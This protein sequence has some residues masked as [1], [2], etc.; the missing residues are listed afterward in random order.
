MRRAGRGRVRRRGHRARRSEPPGQLRPPLLQG[1]R[2]RR[3][4]RARGSAASSGGVGRPGDLGHRTRPRRN[5]V[6][7]GDPRARARLGRVLRLR[8]APHRGLLR[9]QQADEGLHRLGQHRYQLAAVHGLLRRRS[10]A[11]LRFRHR[12]RLLRGPRARRSHRAGRIES[13]LVPSGAASAHCG[14]QGAAAEHAG[15][16][17]RSA[18][19]DDGGHRRHAPAD[20]AGRRRGPVPRTSQASVGHRLARPP[21][22]QGAYVRLPGGAVRSGRPR[23]GRSRSPNRDLCRRACRF[24]RAVCRNGTGGH[25]LQP[26]R[27][28]VL[29]RDRQGQRHHQLPSR[30]GAHRQARS[31]ARSR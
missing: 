2:A 7:A 6:H 23:L 5:E 11:R 25:G 12:A 22:H 29:V 17:D 24:L 4:D 20:Q 3:D 15:G 31:R 19:H 10:Q 9:R 18:P 28:P 1:R 8:P 21:L 14:R 13:R 16:A 30:D 26:G 27:E